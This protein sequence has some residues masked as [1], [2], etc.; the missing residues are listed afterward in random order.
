MTLLKISLCRA[1]RKQEIKEKHGK[2]SMQFRFLSQ[3][4]MGGQALSPQS[5]SS[6][7]EHTLGPAGTLLLLHPLHP[8]PTP[9]AR[10]DCGPEPTEPPCPASKAQI[11]L[12][13]ITSAFGQARCQGS[14]VGSQAK[15]RQWPQDTVAQVTKALHAVSRAGSSSGGSGA[16][17]QP[18]LPRGIT[19][20]GGSG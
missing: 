20:A 11:H 8:L 7:T 14:S 18:H 13:S 3:S 2:T 1:C 15:Q 16:V 6:C 5:C 10:A 19:A 4:V 12:F 17:A 9:A